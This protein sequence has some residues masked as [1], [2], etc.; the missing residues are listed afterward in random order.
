MNTFFLCV[1]VNLSCVQALMFPLLSP[2]PPP[3]PP[4]FSFSF[5]AS[6]GL[7]HWVFSFV[8]EFDCIVFL[9][10]LFSGTEWGIKPQVTYL[11]TGTEWGIKHQVSYLLTGTEWGI[12]HQV[13]MLLTYLLTG[14]EWTVLLFMHYPS[15]F[16]CILSAGCSPVILVEMSFAVCYYYSV[17]SI[18]Y[19]C[20]C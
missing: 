16:L 8:T 20:C 18:R 12:K 19:C 14:T 1:C 11:L 9:Y 2:P 5:C 10:M 13:Y 6:S 17:L 3:P 15:I 7:L 4:L